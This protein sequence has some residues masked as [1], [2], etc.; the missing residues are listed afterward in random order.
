MLQ[1]AQHL[2]QQYQLQAL[3]A[4]QDAAFSGAATDCMSAGCATVAEV[5]KRGDA[6]WDEF[7]FYLSD[8]VVGCVLD[9]VLVGLLAPSAVLG[10]KSKTKP[11]GDHKITSILRSDLLTITVCTVVATSRVLHKPYA[12]TLYQKTNPMMHCEKCSLSRR[13]GGNFIHYKRI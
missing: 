10:P 8:L 2:Q 6:F 11:S 4:W 5:R 12:H 9:C 7:E 1:G 3:H 13:F